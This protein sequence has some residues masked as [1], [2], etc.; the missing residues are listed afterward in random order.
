ME[1]GEAFVSR[2]LLSKIFDR[3]YLIIAGKASIWTLSSRESLI[4]VEIGVYLP[5]F[6]RIWKITIKS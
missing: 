2:F 3:L 4:I 6:M 1:K 5:G